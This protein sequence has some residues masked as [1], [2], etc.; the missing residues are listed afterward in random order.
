M[1]IMNPTFINATEIVIRY[2]IY[3][4]LM[5]G[6]FL[7]VSP[8]F[9][10][11][12]IRKRYNFKGSEKNG[13]EFIKHIERILAVT[14]NSKS[15]V[16][17]TFFLLFSFILGALTF[18]LL[19]TANI[20]LYE[21]I[22]GSIVACLIPYAFLRTRLHSIRI[23]SSYEAEP[24]VAELINQYKINHFN[25]KEA[26]DKSIPKLKKQ[27]WTKKALF[28]LATEL[29]TYKTKDELEEIILDFTFSIDTQWAIELG[30]NIFLS[31]EYGD[32]VRE[33]L[34]DILDD[35]KDL[36][37]VNEK[38]KQIN[39]ESYIMIKYVSPVSYIISVVLLFKNFNFTMSKFIDYQFKD[40]MGLKFFIYTIVTI[41]VNYIIYILIRKP[42]N[43]F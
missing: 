38:N 27:Q 36:N 42:K 9:K 28:R 33:S 8:L 23:E 19:Y 24:V 4:I 37:K 43:D 6:T 3:T 30:N 29:S 35:L 41:I 39:N 5:I 18:I 26:I 25:M 1:N 17:I 10:Y 13:N 15:K 34:E 31:I 11:F 12:K 40:A 14:L 20:V 16:M 7:A 21:V 22:I 32:D 2:I